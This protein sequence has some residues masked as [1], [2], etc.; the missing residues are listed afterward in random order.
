MPARGSATPNAGHSQTNSS[1]PAGAAA[2][3]TTGN[4]RVRSAAAGERE[5]HWPRW[6]GIVL[7]RAAAGAPGGLSAVGELQ[8]GPEGVPG[9]GQVTR[10][11]GQ[12]LLGVA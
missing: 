5:Q 10:P 11:A 3:S 1:G 4:E 12:V 9:R 6:L 2:T 7:W 8:A